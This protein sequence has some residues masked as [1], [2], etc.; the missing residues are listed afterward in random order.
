MSCKPTHHIVH[1][2]RLTTVRLQRLSRLQSFKIKYTEL[3]LSTKNVGRS[4][5]GKHFLNV[6]LQRA[7]KQH[8]QNYYFA[9]C[10]YEQFSKISVFGRITEQSV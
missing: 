9:N 8:W 3:E 5:E 1:H 10:T 6:F 7:S 4:L 2:I